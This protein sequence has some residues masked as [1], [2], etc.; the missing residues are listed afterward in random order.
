M[1]DRR[2]R[3]EIVVGTYEF[4]VN[5]YGNVYYK[6]SMGSLLGWNKFISEAGLANKEL[7]V[8]LREV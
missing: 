8:I 6:D 5:E 4:G 7:E 2:I 1:K 3:K